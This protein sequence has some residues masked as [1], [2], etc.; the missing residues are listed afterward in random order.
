MDHKYRSRR[1]ALAVAALSVGGVS[2]LLGG[3]TAYQA[4]DAAGAA[5]VIE[6]FAVLSAGVLAAYGYTRSKWGAN[7]DQQP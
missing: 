4:S 5:E 3:V 7:D 1:F 6:A 2:T